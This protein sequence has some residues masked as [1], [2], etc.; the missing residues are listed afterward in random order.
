[1]SIEVKGTLEKVRRR[2]LATTSVCE[3][4]RGTS[5]TAKSPTSRLRLA[6][7]GSPAVIPVCGALSSVRAKPLGGTLHTAIC[8]I[9]TWGERGERRS[10][11]TAEAAYWEGERKLEERDRVARRERRGV[12]RGFGEHKAHFVDRNR[13]DNLKVLGGRLSRELKSVQ[14]AHSPSGK[15]NAQEQQRSQ[16]S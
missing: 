10:E 12:R 4:P 8:V 1:M 3:G 2:L 9:S 6:L 5:R 14:L 7:P 15:G 11:G 16:A 13:G